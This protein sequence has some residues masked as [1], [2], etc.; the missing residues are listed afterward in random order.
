MDKSQFEIK[1]LPVAGSNLS[2]SGVASA[3]SK[4]NTATTTTATTSVPDPLPSGNNTPT[5][6][7]PDGTKPGATV[8][9]PDSASTST[10][11]M[12]R[13][14]ICKFFDIALLSVYGASVLVLLAL[15][16]NLVKT[17]KPS[18]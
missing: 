17:A 11:A 13:C 2:T 6:T 10:P 7:S 8:A 1:L 16:Y 4:E 9:K 18:D 12:D 5:N 14:K 3:D 15:A